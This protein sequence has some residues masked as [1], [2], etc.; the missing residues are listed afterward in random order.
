VPPEDITMTAVSAGPPGAPTSMSTGT[1]VWRD[2][3]PIAFSRAGQG[4]RWWWS[5]ARRPAG[6]VRRVG[7]WCRC[8]PGGSLSTLRPARPR[9]QRRHRPVCGR[10]GKSRTWP[11]SSA[12]LGARRACTG[13]LWRHAGPGG[14]RARAPGHPAGTLRAAVHHRRQSAGVRYQVL[15][16]QTHQVKGPYS[17][18]TNSIGLTRPRTC[19]FGFPRHPPWLRESLLTVRTELPRGSTARQTF[20]AALPGRGTRRLAPVHERVL[21]LV[22]EAVAYTK[23][24]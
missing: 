21:S 18:S 13:S 12:R 1:V 24:P 3:T 6:R 8:W 16:G 11:R 4:S 9:R 17:Q 20:A 22:I 14:R 7:S 10:A 2:G 19:A 5:M 23:H 15:G